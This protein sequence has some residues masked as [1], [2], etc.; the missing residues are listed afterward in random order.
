MERK[1]VRDFAQSLQDGRLFD[2]VSK[3]SNTN[4]NAILIIEGNEVYFQ[5]SKLRHEAVEA[6]IAAVALRFKVPVL[7]SE[8][9][10]QTVAL[11]FQCYRQLQKVNTLRFPHIWNKIKKR[12]HSYDPILLKKLKV[13]SSFP[14][15]GPDKSFM[16]VQ[17]FHTLEKIFASSKD[18]FLSVKGMGP[19]TWSEFD[20]I[21][22]E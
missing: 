21:L 18:E 14:G 22:S 16:L 12:S 6:A 11:I 2:Q 17:R 7:R 8:N 3:M 10:F 15:I 1:T 20:N 5:K 13:L 19:K 4:A 9:I